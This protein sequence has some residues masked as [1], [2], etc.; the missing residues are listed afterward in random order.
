MSPPA[1]PAAPAK[2][3]YAST[4]P[5]AGPPRYPKDGN[6]FGP[7]SPEQQLT[8]HPTRGPHRPWKARPRATPA[9]L[10][11]PSGTIN[12]TRRPARTTSDPNRSREKWRLGGEDR[13]EPAPRNAR[14]AHPQVAHSG[15]R[16]V[17]SGN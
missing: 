10:P 6:D 14:F 7:P 17:D 2:S 1:S 12:P 13:G 16:I 11:Y 5:G 4:P 9:D 15:T 8:R 3:A